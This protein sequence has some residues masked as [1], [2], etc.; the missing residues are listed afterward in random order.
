M[1]AAADILARKAEL[2]GAALAARKTAF[3]AGQGN[4]A[5]RLAAVLAPVADAVLAGYVP[6]RTEIDPLPAMAAHADRG[7]RVGV[8]VIPGA[9][10]P[11][12]F[13]EWTPGAELVPGEFGARIP[14]AGDWLV[15]TV[16]IVPLLAFD[17]R[18]YRIGYGGGFYDR[19]LAALRAQGPVIAVGFAFAL[20]EVEEVPVEPT[21]EPLDIIVT[22]AGVIRP[23]H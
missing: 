13:R 16:L 11:L 21:D 5:Q 14:V 8:P 18:G 12:R 6:M 2:R 17:W 9:G 19:T 4:A 10:Q 15:P 23:G 1:S 7:G 20:Q 22:E 3:A